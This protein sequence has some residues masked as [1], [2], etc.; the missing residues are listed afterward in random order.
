[1]TQL[2]SSVKNR[3]D[4][5]FFEYVRRKVFASVTKL[6]HSEIF[7]Y[8]TLKC[9]HMH[10]YNPRQSNGNVW[11]RLGTDGGLWGLLRTS[12]SL[13]TLPTP[14]QKNEQCV[15]SHA[16]HNT[17]AED[18]PKFH[19]SAVTLCTICLITFTPLPCLSLFPQQQQ[20]E[21]RSMRHNDKHAICGPQLMVNLYVYDMSTRLFVGILITHGVQPPYAP[22]PP[23]TPIGGTFGTV[24]HSP[25]R[26]AL[27]QVSSVGV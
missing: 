25:P 14:P 9:T 1:M 18:V 3:D 10:P 27:S 22:L 12:G 5:R 8:V 7:P 15:C 17:S 20:Y 6:L 2:Q 11:R 16:I 13:Y 24:L 4:G 19:A 26:P 21:T 23:L